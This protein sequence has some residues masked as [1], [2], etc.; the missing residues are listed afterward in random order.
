MLVL[1]PTREIAVQ[2][3]DV[4][5]TIGAGIPGLVCGVLIGGI[6]LKEDIEILQKCHVAVGTP[7]A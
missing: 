6:S 1:A 4:F 7:G 5:Q 2:I 3:R